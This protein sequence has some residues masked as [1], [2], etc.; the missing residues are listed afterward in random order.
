MPL[1]RVYLPLT[2]ADLD[3]L[4]EGRDLGPEPVAA[5]AVTP[6]LG[7][8]R[9]GTDEEDLEHDAW[10]AATEEADALRENDERRVVASA[11]VDSGVVAVPTSGEV[12][13]RVE[14][15]AP[16]PRSRIV[17]FHVDEHRGDT[18]T[19]DL[20]WYD[21]TELGAVVELLAGD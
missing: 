13:S 1:T 9:I 20:L 19:A 14:V 18:G 5:H 15:L 2:A 16:V 6:A 11:D 17:S 8:T 21:V 3:A 4:L 10:V 7:R 12:P